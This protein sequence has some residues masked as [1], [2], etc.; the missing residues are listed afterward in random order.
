M[1]KTKL[2]MIIVSVIL[3]IWIWIG[4][5]KKYGWTELTRM[6]DRY[7]EIQSQYKDYQNKMNDLHNEAEQI[8]ETALSNYWLVFTEA[9][10]VQS[11]SPTQ[12]DTNI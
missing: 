8:R 12:D 9:W 4:L 2:I 6:V 3:A 1:N 7:W 11:V 5:Y 10:Q